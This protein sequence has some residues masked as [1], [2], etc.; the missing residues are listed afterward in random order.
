MGLG[1]IRVRAINATKT[2]YRNTR[3]GSF[4]DNN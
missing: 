1:S 4:A 2:F 3:E